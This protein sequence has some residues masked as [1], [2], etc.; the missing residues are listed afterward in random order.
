[1]GTSTHT[2]LR[3]S[4]QTVEFLLLSVISLLVG[5][6]FLV[7]GDAYVRKASESKRWPWVEGSVS[8]SQVRLRRQEHYADIQYHYAVDGESHTGSRISLGWRRTF[9]TRREAQ[10]FADRYRHGT[11]VRVYYDPANPDESVLQPGVSSKTRIPSR[12]G[13]LLL[14]VS[15]IAGA[16]G[17]WRLFRDIRIHNKT[18]QDL[19]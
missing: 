19:K 10:E 3:L 12:L 6:G 13:Y 2:T 1:M 4:F 18:K 5:A 8:H 17:G 15:A 7:Y 11:H 14:A 9:V 16:W